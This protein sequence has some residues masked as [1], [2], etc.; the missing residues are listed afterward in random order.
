MGTVSIK[1]F[2]PTRDSAPY[3]QTYSFPFQPGMS[4]LDV[5]LDIY[6][7][8]DATLS[9]QYCCRNSHCGLCGV[10]IDG[11]PGLVCREAAKQEMRLEPLANLPVLR[12]LTVDRSEQDL[13]KQ[14]LRLFLERAEPYRGG[15]AERVDMA[16]FERFKRAARCVECFCCVSACP[17]FAKKP[18][19]FLGPAALTQLARHFFDPRDEGPRSLIALSGGLAQ[20]IGCGK[21]TAVCPH[22]AMPMENII[23]MQALL[24]EE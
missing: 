10:R 16:A 4:V 12:D 14:D 5:L 22:G 3:W 19:D 24:E 20:C 21:C 13:R 18:H 17:V 11:K 2:D 23:A 8:L 15:K 6:Q 7:R 9:F 1:R